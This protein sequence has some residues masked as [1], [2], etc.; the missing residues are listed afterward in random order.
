MLPIDCK[1]VS[2]KIAF[3]LRQT[4]LKVTI[5]TAAGKDRKEKQLSRNGQAREIY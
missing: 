5:I 4:G 1:G 2:S 3:N